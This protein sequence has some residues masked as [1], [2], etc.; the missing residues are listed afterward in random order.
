MQSLGLLRPAVHQH[1][2]LLQMPLRPRVRA[3]RGV[4]D[5]QGQ[6]HA[7]QN[8]A[9][10]RFPRQ[11]DEGIKRAALGQA[12]CMDGIFGSFFDRLSILKDFEIGFYMGLFQWYA[13]ILYSLV[14]M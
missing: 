10:L 7:R 13:I 14:F 11:I 5:L 6:R 2:R 1:G 12:F 9:L 4:E 8:D 3:R